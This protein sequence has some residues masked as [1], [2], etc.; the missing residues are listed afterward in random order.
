MQLLKKHHYDE[1]KI[2][3][4]LTANPVDL[5]GKASQFG[6]LI[7]GLN[8]NFLVSEGIPG[9]EITEIDRIKL[10]CY[11]GVMVISR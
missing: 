5:L 2:L 6:R 9:L 11:R 1:N 3:A 7:P 8:A 10:V 4:L